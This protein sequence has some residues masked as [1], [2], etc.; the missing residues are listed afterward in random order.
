MEGELS[1]DTGL[2]D[3]DVRQRV[4][5]PGGPDEGHRHLRGGIEDVNEDLFPG[6]EAG[7]EVD[8]EFRKAVATWIMHR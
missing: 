2:V 7:G 3:L 6:F 5:S 1:G 4:G 8:Y